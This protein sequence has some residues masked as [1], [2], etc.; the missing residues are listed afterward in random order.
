MRHVCAQGKLGICVRHLLEEQP[1]QMTVLRQHCPYVD[2]DSFVCERHIPKLD[3][4]PG[5]WISNKP[6]IKVQQKEATGWPVKS[7]RRTNAAAHLRWSDRTLAD[8]RPC[9][10]YSM[11]VIKCPTERQSTPRLTLAA[12]QIHQDP[13][14]D[15]DRAELDRSCRCHGVSVAHT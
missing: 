12:N 13:L 11:A 5:A 1:Q 14:T 6:A 3:Q 2:F 8:Q 10:K 7:Q 15:T 9:P 4:P